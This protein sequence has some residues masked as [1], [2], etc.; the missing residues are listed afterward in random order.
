MFSLHLARGAVTRPLSQ[1]FSHRLVPIPAADRH[2]TDS[3]LGVS[4]DGSPTAA[5]CSEGLVLLVRESSGCHM[6]TKATREP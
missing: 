6:N 2:R 5:G 4:Q 1:P 3:L